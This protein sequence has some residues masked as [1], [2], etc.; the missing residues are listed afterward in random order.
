MAQWLLGLVGVA[1]I[2]V[3]LDV[4]MPAGSTKKVIQCVFAI[5]SI[6]VIIAPLPKLFASTETVVTET[7]VEL[8][9][10]FLFSVNSETV[11]A[12]EKSI[13]NRAEESGISGVSVII[14]ADLSNNE[15]RAKKVYVDFT[16]VVLSEDR[17]NINKYEVL[18]E[19][20][21]HYVDISKEDI[22]FYG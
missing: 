20:I 11:S 21:Q 17:Q 19:I 22:T 15:V 7:G 12:W 2:S 6:Y 8:D 3:I 14:W 9:G 16:N 18:T 1:F 13:V 5:F 10:S 4:V